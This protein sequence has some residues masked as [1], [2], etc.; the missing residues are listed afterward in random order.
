MDNSWPKNVT[1]TAYF[2]SGVLPG[3]I[4]TITNDSE[5]YNL[6]YLAQSTGNTMP[7]STYLQNKVTSFTNNWPSDLTLMLSVENQN[8][9]LADSTTDA[10]TSCTLTKIIYQVNNKQFSSEAYSYTANGNFEG[11]LFANGIGV[12]SWYGIFN[13]SGSVTSPHF[14]VGIVLAW[15]GC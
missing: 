15:F 1:E 9:Q 2:Y 11:T 8:G 12:D 13:Q 4:N 5:Y 14:R 6:L 3:Y 7:L 10:S